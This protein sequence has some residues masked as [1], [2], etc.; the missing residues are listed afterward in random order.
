MNVINING[1]IAVSGTPEKAGVYIVQATLTDRGQTIV[2][3]QCQLRI[4]VDDQTLQ[5]RF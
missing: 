5:Q 4:Y 2:S 3:N 1:T